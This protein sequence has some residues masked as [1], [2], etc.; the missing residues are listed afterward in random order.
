M[1][2]L[3]RYWPVTSN[4]LLKRWRMPARSALKLGVAVVRVVLQ[5]VHDR[6]ERHALGG[7]H[8]IQVPLNGQ[9]ARRAALVAERGDPLV[10]RGRTRLRRST[11]QPVS[12]AN[13]PGYPVKADLREVRPRDGQVRVRIEIRDRCRIRPVARERIDVR[14]EAV[15][16]VDDLTAGQI[17][18]ASTGRARCLGR[19]ARWPDRGRYKRCL[20][21]RGSRA[22]R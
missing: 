20:R 11:G 12:S 1:L 6:V 4:E 8:P 15:H 21:R 5:I 16:A 3:S 9:V 13:P 2:R 17:A 7:E 10:A 18:G 22:A 14:R 19:S